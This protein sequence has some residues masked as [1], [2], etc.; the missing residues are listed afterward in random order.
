MSGAIDECPQVK[1]VSGSF[2]RNISAGG[3]VEVAADT[4]YLSRP[5]RAL[6]S[7]RSTE[8]VRRHD[9]IVFP[10]FYAGH[11]AQ[12]FTLTDQGAD[13]RP[14]QLGSNRQ[15]PLTI[16]SP[17]VGRFYRELAAAYAWKPARNDLE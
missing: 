4:G 7:N 1:Y 12:G 10:G 17:S 6:C 5:V 11:V 2:R 14:M 15:T 9:E 8:N 3:P 16:F 13:V